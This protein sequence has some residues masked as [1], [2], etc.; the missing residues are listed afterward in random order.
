MLRFARD[1]LFLSG[2]QPFPCRVPWGELPAQQQ[3][4]RGVKAA[5]YNEA[6]LA[7]L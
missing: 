3:Q 5:S 1:V 2:R 4:A 7:I 6:S